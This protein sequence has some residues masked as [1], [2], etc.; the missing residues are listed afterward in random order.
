MDA[1]EKLAAETAAM[2]S[3]MSAANIFLLR[4]K[5]KIQI[6]FYDGFL[7]RKY[8]SHSD[9]SGRNGVA[10]PAGTGNP[11]GAVQAL[12]DD[13]Q[14]TCRGTEGQLRFI[15]LS[16]T[17]KTWLCEHFP[18]AQF[19]QD[20]GNSDYL[21]TAEHLAFLAGKK[22]HKKRNHVSR[23]TKTFPD[24]EFEL[25]DETSSPD[26]LKIEDAWLTEQK[27]SASGISE[28]MNF[29]RTEIQEA[30]AHWNKL[31]LCGAILR[32]NGTPAAMTIASEISPGVFD[33]HFEKSYGIYAENGGF[34][35]INMKFA[36]HLLTKR[37][38]AWLNRE[39]DVNIEGLRKA[40]LSY[41]PDLLLGKYDCI[42]EESKC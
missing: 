25:Y 34:A 24:F 33:I 9:L 37:D 6:A 11:Q 40:K 14:S 41:H 29:E 7:I 5:Y 15:F 31:K 36:E 4:H 32:V 23:F 35:A 1:I 21:Y 12:I 42:P 28:S 16:E 30:I 10:F 20:A 8:V 38:A 19:F 13:W 18:K 26:F 17:Q 22:N 3:D 2:G 27:E 39:E